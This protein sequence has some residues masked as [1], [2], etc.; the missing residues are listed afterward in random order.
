MQPPIIADDPTTENV[1][2]QLTDEERRL[3][4]FRQY[5]KGYSLPILVGGAD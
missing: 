5:R 3:K 1:T 4:L 2:T